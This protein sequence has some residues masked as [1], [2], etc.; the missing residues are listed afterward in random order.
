MPILRFATNIPQQM[1]LR[2]LEGKPVESQFGGFQHMFSAEEGAF[3][4]SDKVGGILMDQFRKLGVNVGDLIEICK[5]ETGNGTG[6]KTQWVVSWNPDKTTDTVEPPSELEQKLA[7]SIAH[8]EAKKA[9]QRA[10]VAVPAEQPAWA[11]ALANQTRQLIDVY[12]EAVAYASQRHGNSVKPE[13]VRSMMTT[14]FINMSKSGG[15][16]NAA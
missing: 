1:H 2:S 15:S 16:A 7:D 12:A 10:P 6:R 5:S 11:R 3:Y 9:A 13:D 14:L 4:V 8:V